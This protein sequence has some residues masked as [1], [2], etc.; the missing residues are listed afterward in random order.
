MAL[1]PRFDSRAVPLVLV[2]VLI[3]AIGFG[4]VMPVLPDLVVQLGHVDLAAAARI[5]G[6]LLAV[7]AGAQFFAGPVLGNLADA[8]GR[9]P[10]LILSM[11]AFS[12]DY[13]L[14]A[15]A[16]TLLWLFV[17]RL[18]AGVAGAT[19]GPAGAVIADVTLPDRRSAAFGLLSAAFGLGFILGPALGGLVAPLGPRAPFVVAAVCAGV[20]AVVMLLFLPETLEP[21]HRRPFRLRDAH[22]IESF[23][24]LFNAGPAAPLIIAW[25]LWQLGGVVY[26]ATWSFWA[27][28]TLGW[29][30]TAIGWSLAYVGFMQVLVQLLL[31]DRAVRRLGEKRA[32]AFGMG[33]A[34]ATLLAYAFTTQG[35][36]V[37]AFFVVGALGALAY[38]AM[39]GLVTRLVG[40]DR[41]GALQGGL[42][43]VNSVAAIAGPVIAAQALATGTRHGFA[44]TAFLVAG[45]LLGLS[46]LLIAMLRTRQEPSAAV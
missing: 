44:G 29:D 1:L 30:A 10:V 14:M 27:A 37:Y 24:P 6:W 43:S 31:T 32:A 5:S 42:A 40:A 19:H 23:R 17:G 34:A 46:T 9:R 22:V 38:P 20:N 25:F 3:D 12:I 13:A 36:Q 41:Q 16:P 26:P 11:A 39:S 15:A 33:C 4:I 28:I 7:F 2:A 8:Y 21:A 45:V 18:V 35:W